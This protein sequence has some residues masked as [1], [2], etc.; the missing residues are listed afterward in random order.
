MRGHPI[1]KAAILV[2]WRNLRGL[3]GFDPTGV[4]ADRYIRQSVFA[5]QEQCASLISNI[6]GNHRYRCA[7]RVYDGWH[8]GREP[9]PDR[10]NLDRA[11]QAEQGARFSR[12]IGR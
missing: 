2:D 12:T 6:S 1:G 3:S 10:N 9:T 7:I 8:V 5:V 4:P 11:F